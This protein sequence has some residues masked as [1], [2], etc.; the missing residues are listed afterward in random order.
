MTVA[1]AGANINIPFSTSNISSAYSFFH[2]SAV[3][4]NA[5]L[6]KKSI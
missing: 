4:A 1:L 2:L 5:G 3:T 6:N